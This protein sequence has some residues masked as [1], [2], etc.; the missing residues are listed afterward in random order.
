MQFE[1]SFFLSSD[2]EKKLLIIKTRTMGRMRERERDRE[3]QRETERDR[4][5]IN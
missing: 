3:R 4:E 1:Q 5:E 2:I